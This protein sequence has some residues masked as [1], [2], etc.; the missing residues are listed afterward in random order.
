MAEPTWTAL[1]GEIQATEAYDDGVE[2]ALRLLQAT[3]QHRAQLPPRAYAANR[4]RLYRHILA[5]LDRA[6]R[7]E[8]YLL[9]W[10]AILLQ[11]DLCLSLKGEAIADN[12]ALGALVRRAD[13]GLGAAPAPY[14]VA[15]PARVEVHFLHTSL[16][17]KARAAKRLAAERRQAPSVR[18]TP[19]VAVDLPATEI[20]RRLLAAGA[21]AG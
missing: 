3:V 17:R 16:G 21:A 6:E 2:L 14:G 19:R 20:Q 5:M 1:W 7:W 4:I 8:A 10:D 18:P 15:R 12:P 9:A 13:G 11:T